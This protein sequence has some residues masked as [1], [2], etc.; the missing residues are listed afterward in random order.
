M[1]GYRCFPQKGAI[2]MIHKQVLDPK[3]VRRLPKCRLSL[4]HSG[5]R[6]RQERVVLLQR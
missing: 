5:R 6:E 4:L 2:N 1:L 3:R